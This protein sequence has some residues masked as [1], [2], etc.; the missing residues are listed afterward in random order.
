MASYGIHG[1]VDHYADLPEAAKLD[2]GTVFLV[3]A[4]AGAPSGA[5]LYWVRKDTGGKAWVYLDGLSMQRAD[6]VPYDDTA[7]ALPVANVQQAIDLLAGGGAALEAFEIHVDPA[8][9]I[10]APG[11]GGPASPFQTIAYAF[12][13]VSDLGN[14]TPALTQWCAEQLIFRLAPGEYDEGDILLGL[15]RAHI[16][17]QGQGVVIPGDVGLRFDLAD[18]PTLKEA[19]LDDGRTL[20]NA[21]GLPWPLDY[22]PSPSLTILGETPAFDGGAQTRSVMIGGRVCFDYTEPRA[23]DGTH[24]GWYGRIGLAYPALVN[25][26]VDGGFAVTGRASRALAQLY[27]DNVWFMNGCIGV[28]CDADLLE[29]ATVLLRARHAL[30]GAWGGGCVLGSNVQISEMRSCWV[31]GMDRTLALPGGFITTRDDGIRDCRFTGDVFRF[32][33]SSSPKSVTLDAASFASLQAR[34]AAGADWDD[35]HVDYALLD[36]AAGVAYDGA[37]S[38]TGVWDGDAPVDLQEAVRRLALAVQTLSGG[39]IA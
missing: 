13:Q 1:C 31:N 19:T 12:G 9:G 25:A 8:H 14:D 11:R 18:I 10:D 28:D 26:R 29:T 39:A 2:L 30:V 17:L 27:V 6:E 37:E 36:T 22:F 35:A 23:S 24:Q 3:R 33:G 20:V 15:K 38:Q 21:P 34:K 5:G 4:D 16:V 7:S 32:G